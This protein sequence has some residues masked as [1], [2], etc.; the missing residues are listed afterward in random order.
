[1]TDKHLAIHGV[2]NRGEQAIDGFEMMG[3]EAARNFG[4]GADAVDGEAQ[5]AVF[6]QAGD[7]GFDEHLAAGF[8]GLAGEFGLGRCFLVCLG[9]GGVGGA[10]H[11]NA[12]PWLYFLEHGGIGKS[13]RQDDGL[14]IVVMKGDKGLKADEDEAA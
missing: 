10:I 3:D 7:A 1:M 4:L 11:D 6:R 12:A 13:I 8:G 9:H 2:I 14:Q 5:D